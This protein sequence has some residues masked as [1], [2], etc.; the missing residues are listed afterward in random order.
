MMREFHSVL[1]CDLSRKAA[2]QLRRELLH[3]G[4]AVDLVITVANVAKG[5]GAQLYPGTAGETIT[6]GQSCYLDAADTKLKLADVNVT[7]KDV[8]HGI[9]LHGSLNG[10]PLT[11]ITAGNYN[12]GATVAIGTIYVAS[13]TPGGIAPVADLVSGWKT[14]ILGIATTTTN[15][16]LGINNSG[17]AVP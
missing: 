13:A 14:S 6:A 17:V 11:V 2:R 10:Q 4:F 3:H 15:I 5:T 12:P 8:I 1:S 16:K 9:A 7:G